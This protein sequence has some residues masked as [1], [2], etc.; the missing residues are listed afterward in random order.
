MEESVDNGEVNCSSEVDFS[1]GEKSDFCMKVLGSDRV[2][3]SY[4]NL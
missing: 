4:C 1:V 3:F 2:I